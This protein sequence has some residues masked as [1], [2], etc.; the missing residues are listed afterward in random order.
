M[1]SLLTCLYFDNPW[2]KDPESARNANTYKVIKRD[3]EK[4]AGGHSLAMN[5]QNVPIQLGGLCT[6]FYFLG[7]YLL[8]PNRMYASESPTVIND[9][10]QLLAIN[11]VPDG[12]WLRQHDA[13]GVFTYSLESTSNGHVVLRTRFRRTE[14][15]DSNLPAAISP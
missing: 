4:T 13:A 10:S 2:R 15:N 11:F 6:P 14:S 3:V 9:G 5:F 12:N 1:G 8:W 7:N